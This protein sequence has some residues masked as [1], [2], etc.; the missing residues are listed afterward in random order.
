M[1]QREAHERDADQDR[2]G[3]DGATGEVGE[4]VVP[5]R[6]EPLSPLARRGR[7]RRR[8]AG[9]GAKGSGARPRAPHPRPSARLVPSARGPLP[10][11][12][13]R[14]STSLH[15]HRS[16]GRRTS[17]WAGRSPSP[18]RHGARR[19]VVGDPEERRFLD[20]CARGARR[21]PRRAVLASKAVRASVISSSNF[22]AEIAPVV[23]H[24]RRKSCRAVKRTMPKNGS[25][26][27]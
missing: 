5:V 11:G 6:W 21:A 17:S 18:S 10:A 16:R 23:R 13:E 27:A 19:D 2:D 4:H 15:R 8:R 25:I 12:G 20:R 22:V 3:V 24:R 9:R 7:L 1:H 26:A 14:R